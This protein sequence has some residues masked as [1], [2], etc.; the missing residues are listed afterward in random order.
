MENAVDDGGEMLGPDIED[1]QFLRLSTIRSLSL[2]NL[3]DDCE[4]LDK[5]NHQMLRGAVR[6]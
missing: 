4:V 1:C 5:Y 3:D 6:S 2:F